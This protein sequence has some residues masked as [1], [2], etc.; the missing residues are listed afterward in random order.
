[1]FRFLAV[2][3]ALS[4][5]SA[6][7]DNI[8][9]TNLVVNACTYGAVSSGTLDCTTAVNNALAAIKTAGGGT[10]YFPAG[11]Y[12]ITGQILVPS[13]SGNGT[14]LVPTQPYLAIRGAGQDGSV[15]NMTY[16][17]S[18]A[19]LLTL[20][21]GVVDIGSLTFTDTA[22][23]GTPWIYDTNSVLHVHDTNF[24]G[25]TTLSGTACNQDAIVLGAATLSH[26]Q[27]FTANPA[28]PF[29]GYGTTIERCTFY[30]VR[31]GLYA[32][33]AANGVSF[34]DNHFL[35][36]C[37]S[38]LAG[39]AAVELDYGASGNVIESNVIE[40]TGYAYAV[41]V[42]SA[43]QNSIL[44]NGLYDAATPTLGKV[45]L[46][47]SSNNTTIVDGFDA[48]AIVNSSTSPYT[49]LGNAGP[50]ILGGNVV[51]ATP[52]VPF[53]TQNSIYLLNAG[54]TSPTGYAN[55]VFG[56]AACYS[57]TSGSQNSAWGQA[58]LYS[59]TTG[60]GNVACGCLGLYYNTTGHNNTA[61]GF[62]AGDYGQTLATCS[63]CSF[64]GCE[65]WA[66]SD[67]LSNATAIGYQAVATASNQV[68]LGNSSAVVVAPGM[69]VY[70]NNAAATAAG[71]P[72]GALYRITG[73]DTVGVVH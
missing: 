61:L 2:A 24:R 56:N 38:N 55:T 18:C 20:G 3:L 53:N 14:S 42:G 9:P 11:N 16:S 6:R 28:N 22:A 35:S 8:Y 19:K 39:G 54:G 58:A 21:Q 52:A 34:R 26:T 29:T 13:T 25:A 10:L 57:L 30:Q 23:T 59:N 15:L 50:Y 48:L 72:V 27:S 40:M 71:L 7:A 32:R 69:P 37:G 51:A 68:V 60:Y 43:A 33:A 47:A 41:S 4:T 12:L 67:G 64:I 62:R 70:A 17:G 45:F 1:M 73:T 44:A 65:A 46:S 66:S 63:N 36:T 31:R 5:L 49:H